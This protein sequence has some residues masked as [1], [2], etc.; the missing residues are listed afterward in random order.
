MHVHQSIRIRLINIAR[1]LDRVNANRHFLINIYCCTGQMNFFFFLGKLRANDVYKVSYIIS[2][3][4]E[5]FNMV[6]LQTQFIKS[7][8]YVNV[9]LQTL[10]TYSMPSPKDPVFNKDT[11]LFHKSPYNIVSASKSGDIG[12][13]LEINALR[14]DFECTRCMYAHKV[15]TCYMGGV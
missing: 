1:K 12:P 11:S 15:G 2:C 9:K 5:C 8:S 3:I 13:L 10:D 14:L 4:K 7:V 6:L